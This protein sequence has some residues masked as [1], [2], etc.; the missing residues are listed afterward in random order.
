MRSVI[1]DTRTSCPSSAAASCARDIGA[2][3]GLNVASNSS[4]IRASIEAGPY[5]EGL[6]ARNLEV[7]FC[8]EPV[9]E[10]VMNNVREFD[11]KKITAADHADVKLSDLPKPDGALSDDDVK[12]L[13]TW[14]KDTLGE[15]VDEA[16]EAS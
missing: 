15:R 3:S 11:S 6:K 12:T 16:V 5:L 10:Y 8:Y 9:D 4:A 13:T 1:D 2:S 7:L 14:L